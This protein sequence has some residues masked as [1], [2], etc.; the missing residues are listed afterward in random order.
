MIG[1]AV[2]RRRIVRVDVGMLEQPEVVASPLV[3]V[4]P[5]VIA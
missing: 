4:K 1:V 2:P 5:A 3:P